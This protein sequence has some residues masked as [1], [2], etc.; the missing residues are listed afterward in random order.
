M[1]SSPH[2]D[3]HRCFTYN[4]VVF[5]QGGNV[6]HDLRR[7]R[8]AVSAAAF[9]VLLASPARAQRYQVDTYSEGDGLASSTV[10]GMVQD[11]SGRM[12]FATRAG[13]TVYDGRN[14]SVF[15]QA[16]D[17]ELTDLSMLALDPSG[18]I[19]AASP[20][21][22]VARFDGTKWSMVP[23]PG[24]AKSCGLRDL[25]VL[26]VEEGVRVVLGTTCGVELWDGSTWRHLGVADGLPD[27]EVTA[28]EMVDGHL[29]VATLKGLAVL[30][31]NSANF[32][33]P[34]FDVRTGPVLGLAADASAPGGL[35]VVG[36]EWLGR[37]EAG[38]LET[39]IDKL[40]TG[41]TEVPLKAVTDG[42]R[43]C[44][45]GHSDAFYH[46][47]PERGIEILD[48]VNGLITGGVNEV[49]RDREHNVWVSSARGVSKIVSF[50]FATYLEEHGLYDDE[51]TAVLERRN[52]S[53]VF[54]HSGGLTFIDGEGGGETRTVEFP[55]VRRFDRTL[56]RVLDLAEDA[57]GTVW[58][59]GN[60]LGLGRFDGERVRWLSS[61]G[62]PVTS[63]LLTREVESRLWVATGS[64][65]VVATA[66]GFER[67]SQG[68]G[69]D[70][71]ARRLIAEDNGA[72]WALTAG[73]GAHRFLEGRWESWAHPSRRDLNDVFA[74]Y[75]HGGVRWLGTAG[76]LCVADAGTIEPTRPP[77]PVIKRPV[78]FMLRDTRDRVWFGTDNGVL[79]WDGEA[80]DHFTVEDG[81][82]GRETN[83]AAGW[84]DSRG[85]VWIGTTRGV[86]AYRDEFDRGVPVPPIV[87]LHQIEASGTLEPIAGPVHL[88][89]HRNDI[90][91]SVRAISF[92]DERDVRIRTWLEGY[93]PG[94]SDERPVGD[95]RLR[96]T[97][98]SPG[99]YQLH[100]RAGNAA[101]LWTEPVSSHE[102]VIASPFYGR[103]WFWA[104]MLAATGMLLYAS[105][106]YIY[107]R[108][109]ARRLEAEVAARVAELRRAEAELLKAQRLESLGVMAGGIAHDFNNLLMVILGNLSLV[110]RQVEGGARR[111][112]SDAEAAI[113]R[114]RQLTA[115]LLTFARGGA[116][117]RSAAHVEDVVRES[118]SFVLRGSNARCEIDL[119]PDLRVVGIDTGQ[120]NQVLNNL[121]LNAIQAM[122][123][124]G[125][126]RI[127]GRN[128]DELPGATEPGS[129]VEISV[130]DEGTG[131]PEHNLQRIFDPYFTTK[132][133]GSG[134]GLTTA[135]S[136]ARR[137][138]GLLTVK[139]K[140]GHGA[141]FHLYLPE[142]KTPRE[143]ESDAERGAHSL[144]GTR[145]MIMEDD[146]AVRDV[147]VAM[148][149]SLE[150]T[151][152]EASDGEEAVR[153]YDWARTVGQ[154]FDAVIL[155]LTL[156]GG[157]GGE[158]VLRHLVHVDP[159]VRAIVASGY[160]N[161]S[162][163]SEYRDHGFKAA[164]HK[165][166][167][168]EEV[169]EVL[170]GVVGARPSRVTPST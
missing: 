32:S 28:L 106:R 61:V 6:K 123:S 101:G 75:E 156:P 153:L 43:G 15:H 100:L 17:V 55:E 81:L 59:A 126:I 143:P 111:W 58:V 57:Q 141:T 142:S 65:V 20:K 47:H 53:F 124:G 60:H 163:M 45:F 2:D 62:K 48:S 117:V 87:S 167:R 73:K 161:A 4:D 113:E 68:E 7:L 16:D 148:L 76:G 155:D 93:E 139:S 159:G 80:L 25:A 49:Y 96:Y 35:W 21:N 34:D 44:F 128:V 158:E 10:R 105:Q 169:A 18:S 120:I 108:R 22:D 162:A 154:P 64:D 98:L 91:F 132:E 166:F 56:G 70:H 152:T 69:F 133:E 92:Y 129:Y 42:E 9:A 104:I 130:R 66:E 99:R 31:G 138:G 103:A 118:T 71:G 63:V 107:Q 19:W 46:Y 89:H 145:I 168:R 144:H 3:V 151:V 30:D 79:R 74:V 94:W 1:K 122:P 116:P 23:P 109:H 112:I 134:L 86:T 72:V 121:L 157:M 88:E 119:S 39:I 84:L 131:I 52:G 12:W 24:H 90:V 13:I 54:G 41:A 97:N 146:A 125:T 67:V 127:T 51:V 14:W 160:A 147:V 26:T 140:I 110:E 5:S 40:E 150:C 82:G 37:V 136:I 38:R 164:L 36:G 102:I 95:G 50:R 29:Y 137:H 11:H 165:P 78:Y 115:Q 85:H 83:R 149:E 33:P 77:A 135:Y 170:R 27:A 8:I 114:A